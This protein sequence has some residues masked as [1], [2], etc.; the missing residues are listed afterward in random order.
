MINNCD[1]ACACKGGFLDGYMHAIHECISFVATFEHYV[2]D[3][4]FKYIYCKK[5]DAIVVKILNSTIC[6]FFV[7]GVK[8]R[9]PLITQP[10]D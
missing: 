3:P 9:E 1:S 10:R 4:V 5:E 7:I 8:N 6:H 2:S